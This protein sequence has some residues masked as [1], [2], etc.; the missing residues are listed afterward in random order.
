M[1]RIDPNA[2]KRAPVAIASERVAVKAFRPAAPRR[3]I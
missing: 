1:E 3:Q 2:L